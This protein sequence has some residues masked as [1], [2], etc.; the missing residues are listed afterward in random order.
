MGAYVARRFLQAVPTLFGLSIL[1]FLLGALAGDPS[2]QLAASSAPDGE[3]SGEQIEAVRRQLGLDRPLSA[4]YATWLGGA[5]QGDF[6]S[7]LTTSRDVLGEIRRAFPATLALAVTALVLIVA[8]AVPMGAAG[9]LL[10]NRWGD[11]LVRVV[12]LAGASLPGFFLAYLLIDLFAVRLHLLPVAGLTGPR[13]LVLPAFTLSVG[14]AAMVARLLRSSLLDSLGEE[15]VLA[16]RAKG[17]AAVPVLLNHALRNAALP[18][19]TVLGNVFGR[20]LEGAVV[21]E[22]VF[23][24]PG[25]GLLTYGAILVYDYPVVVGTVLFAGVI[26][27]MLNLAVDLCY[28][29]VDPRVRLGA[30]A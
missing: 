15:Y 19:L 28:G 17:L 2:E 24:W 29:L 21:V 30:E 5:L 13:S 8:L 1:I 7:S 4:R 14:P 27:M 23:S 16:A 6:G 10:H 12:T 22:V 25:L 18:L 11:H 26:F 20:M 9:A 3:A